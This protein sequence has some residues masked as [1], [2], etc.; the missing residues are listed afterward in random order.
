MQ[1]IIVPYN[2]R[3]LPAFFV[4]SEDEGVRQGMADM[5]SGS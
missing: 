5:G 1:F 3:L 2:R 4:L